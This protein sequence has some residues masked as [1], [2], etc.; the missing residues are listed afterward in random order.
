[1]SLH[2][3]IQQIASVIEGGTS[4]GTITCLDIAS[5]IFTT[6]LP[7][8]YGLALETHSFRATP[9]KRQ[10]RYF[11]PAEMIPCLADGVQRIT[12][13][14]FYLRQSIVSKI[15]QVAANERL[16]LFVVGHMRMELGQQALSQIARS[17]A[18]RV[19]RLH[20]FQGALGFL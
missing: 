1:M 17:D 13:D 4:F 15:F 10:S 9:L 18:G 6:Q 19:Q 20:E 2:F 14:P 11:K 16:D 7:G 5:D 3:A 12:G 8:T